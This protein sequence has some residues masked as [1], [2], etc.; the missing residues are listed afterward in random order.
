MHPASFS[1]FIKYIAIRISP[2]DRQST[3]QHLQKKWE[4]MRH[5]WP[6]EYFFM[7]SNLKNL[8]KAEDKL[9]SVTM[10]FSGLS[11]LVGSLGLFGLATYSA[12]LRSREM[13]IRKVLGGS[14]T[15]I[16][17]LFCKG[18]V[19]EIAIAVVIA[20]PASWLILEYWLSTFSYRTE[21]S[22]KWLIAGPLVALTIALV[23]V[24][25]HAI[26]LS[27]TDP[28]KVLKDE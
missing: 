19:G 25:Y 4:T 23:T 8:Y 21:I 9:S 27:N 24:S 2:E 5:G 3:I 28:A 20:V 13:S 12:H 6:F 26:W 15:E 16:F 18:F 22:V 10:I 7:D 11:I 14:A 17:M 1:V